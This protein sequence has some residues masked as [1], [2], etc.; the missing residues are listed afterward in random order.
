MDIIIKSTWHQE[1][2]NTSANAIETSGAADPREE[3]E[4]MTIDGTGATAPTTAQISL[5]KET[6]RF[7]I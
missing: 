6:A 3:I 2:I 4:R 5:S 7:P 1:F